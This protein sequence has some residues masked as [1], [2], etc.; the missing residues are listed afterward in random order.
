MA[1]GKISFYILE[2]TDLARVKPLEYCIIV[3]PIQVNL[4][5]L[6]G[7]AIQYKAEQRQMKRLA[8]K[9]DDTEAGSVDEKQA[10]LPEA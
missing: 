6:M 4:G 3:L 10:L 5:I 9:K 8:A 1:I 2:Q 7:S